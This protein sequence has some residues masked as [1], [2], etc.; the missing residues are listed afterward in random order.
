MTEVQGTYTLFI[1]ADTILTRSP[2]RRVSYSPLQPRQ[3]YRSRQPRFTYGQ[4]APEPDRYSTSALY[5]IQ[6]LATRLTYKDI[7]LP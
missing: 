7:A 4:I 1:L 3:S 6:W 2:Y 5:H